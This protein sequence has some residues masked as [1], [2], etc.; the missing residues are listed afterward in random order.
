MKKLIIVG[1]DGFASQVYQWICDCNKVNFKW[2]IIGFLDVTSER[3]CIIA[4]EVKAL[5]H[6][7]NYKYNSENIFFACGIQLP[8]EKEIICRFIQEKDCKFVNVIHPSCLIADERYLG[9]G[10][11]FSPNSFISCNVNLGDF[12]TVISASIAHDVS[13]DSFST[14]LAFADPTGAVKIGRNCIIGENAVII[15][16]VI[17][18]DH[19]IVHP[20]S[21]VMRN[22]PDG[23][24][25]YGNPARRI[26]IKKLVNR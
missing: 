2:D 17:L 12:I 24:E 11:V 23:S 5:G 8:K 9:E 3:H 25:V 18:G 10:N 1:N 7:K 20:N 21:V 6:Y 19:C 15:P 4:S 14:I 22:L 26:K 16:K 13:V